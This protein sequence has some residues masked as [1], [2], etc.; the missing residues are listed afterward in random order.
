VATEDS[1]LPTCTVGLWIEA[2][3]RYETDQNSGIAHF[4]EHMIFKGTSKRSQTDLE[5][6]IESMGAHLNA[7]TGRDQTAIYGKCLSKDAGKMVEILSDLVQDAKF[8]ET[9]IN[10]EKSVILTELQEVETDLEKVTL[11]YLHGT[12]YQGTALARSVYGNVENIKRFKKQDMLDYVHSSFKPPRMVLA[13]AGGVN[14]KELV[15][16]AQKH[17]KLSPAYQGRIPDLE[18]PCRFV[19]SEVRARDDDSPIAHVAMAVEGCGRTSSDRLVL[20]VA[21]LIIGS[22]DRTYGGGPHVSSSLAEAS[23][24][25]KLCHSFKS[26][27][28]SYK[29]TGLWGVYFVAEGCSDH[30]VTLDDF[31]FVLQNEWM[32]LC[33]SVTA[34]DVERAKNQLT[35]NLLSGLSGTTPV[36]DDIGSQILWQGVRYTPAQL[37]AGIQAI[38]EHM[39]RDVCMKYIYDRCPAISAVGAVESLPDYNR[40]RGNM[41]WLRF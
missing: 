2:G 5:K 27:N 4:V 38:D 13:A 21:S 16:L 15:D 23:L 28:A 36:C 6:E 25:G 8:D 10:K 30:H 37:H 17:L 12:A 33:T 22:W 31:L 18:I 29:D 20:D 35:T 11:D 9:E 34:R 14:H 3:S 39:V 40:I 19:G 24:Q 1:G 32:R 41:Y 26:F 7:Y